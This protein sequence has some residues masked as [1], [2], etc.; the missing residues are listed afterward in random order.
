MK[1]GPK[2]K[3]Q[4]TEQT[5]EQLRALGRIHCTLDEAAAVLRTSNAALLRFFKSHPPSLDAF[6]GGKMEGKASLRRNQ[7]RIAESNPTM[8]IWLGKQYL[9][10]K[11]K[12]ESLH[13]LNASDAF[14][15]MLQ[16]VSGRTLIE[17]SKE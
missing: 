2:A 6:E 17:G 8:Q 7:F 10:Q 3:L 15:R 14:L 4:P 9:E 16:T 1:P 13:T 12:S 5:I 11:D